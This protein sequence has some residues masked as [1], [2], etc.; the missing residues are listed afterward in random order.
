MFNMFLQLWGSLFYLLNKIFFSISERRQDESSHK[1]Y[2]ILAWVVYLIALPAWVIVFML[3]NNWIAAAVEAGAA[4]SMF[5]GLWIACF[6]YGKASVWLDYFSFLAT[7]VGLGL[8]LYSFH[9]ITTFNQIMELGIAAGFLIGTYQLAKKN[10]QG[11]LWFILGNICCAEL[12]YRE[13]LW[14]LMMQQIIS[15]IFVVDAFIINRRIYLSKKN[16]KLQSENQKI[17]APD[18]NARL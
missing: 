13:G 16:N 17:A 11:Y 6:G 5:A 8:S 2:L 12:M 9:G 3:K 18:F 10:P 7:T 14:V 1:K 15:L 4:P